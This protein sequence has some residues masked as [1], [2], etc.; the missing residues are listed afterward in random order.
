M[1]L[2]R[3]GGAKNPVAQSIDTII[4]KEEDQSQKTGSN[5]TAARKDA[6]KEKLA[7]EGPRPGERFL[8]YL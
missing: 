8:L 7:A 5:L 2:Q 6:V 4:K 3:F 1:W